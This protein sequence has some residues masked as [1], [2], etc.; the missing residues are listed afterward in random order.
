[1]QKA[2]MV[3]LADMHRIGDAA[4]NSTFGRKYLFHLQLVP[5]ITRYALLV[6]RHRQG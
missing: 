3:Q 1:M 2:A 4:A 6:K 5:H